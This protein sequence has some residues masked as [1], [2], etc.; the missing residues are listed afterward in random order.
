LTP[1]Q[2]DVAELINDKDPFTLE[3][4]HSIEDPIY[5]RFKKKSLALG[6]E[7]VCVSLESF[8]MFVQ[9]EAG[10]GKNLINLELNRVMCKDGRERNFVISERVWILSVLESPQTMRNNFRDYLQC[11]IER[12]TQLE[13]LKEDQN[14]WK[15]VQ[16]WVADLLDFSSAEERL[17]M[18]TSTEEGICPSCPHTT[19]PLKRQNFWE[20]YLCLTPLTCLQP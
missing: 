13:G 9:A 16:F 11:S 20:A 3:D 8:E 18:P 10:A 2:P 1:S 19:S 6:D 17:T 15:R 14:L 4:V 7:I 12:E 5:L